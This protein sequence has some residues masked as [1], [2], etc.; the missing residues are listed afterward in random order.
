[1]EDR[2]KTTSRGRRYSPGEKAEILGD[3]RA[4]SVAEAAEKHG[5]SKWTIYDW[6]NKEKRKAAKQ[7]KLA[8]EREPDASGE[9]DGDEPGNEEDPVQAEREGLIL[10]MWRQQPGLGPSQI[11]NQLKRKGFKASVN[12][13]RTIME[14]HGYVQPRARRKEHTGQYEATRP[15]QLV[16]L[17]FV[18]FHVHRQK[19]CM[20]LMVT[21][22]RRVR[23][24]APW[25]P[26][27]CWSKTYWRRPATRSGFS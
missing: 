5:A 12:T 4:T 24:S 8:A 10:E 27:R 25:R 18:H 15:L 1:M 11:R 13:V 2:K 26:R 6:L 7:S 20:L 21:C 14:E 22:A 19:Q 23:R 3:A 9:S 16:H 17:D